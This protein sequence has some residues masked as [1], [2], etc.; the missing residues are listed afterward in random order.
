MANAPLKD[1]FL[2]LDHLPL[3]RRQRPVVMRTICAGSLWRRSGRQNT[4]FDAAHVFAAADAE[5]AALDA[6][7]F[8]VQFEEVTGKKAAATGIVQLS[9]PPAGPVGLHA[10]QD[11][12]ADESSGSLRRINIIL[13]GDRPTGFRVSARTGGDD[14]AAQCRSTGRYA[15]DAAVRSTPQAGRVCVCH[16]RKDKG[17]QGGSGGKLESAILHRQTLYGS[18]SIVDR[19]NRPKGKLA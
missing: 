2:A 3:N 4:S 7:R 8:G 10:D 6:H 16:R 9:R 11:R 12:N 14:K 18:Q 5:R 17:Y 13:V 15:R 1:W 19:P